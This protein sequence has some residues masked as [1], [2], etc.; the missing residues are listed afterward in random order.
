MIWLCYRAV[1]NFHSSYAFYRALAS[2]SAVVMPLINMSDKCTVGWFDQFA[3][4]IAI[5]PQSDGSTI[6]P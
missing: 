1:V 4:L 2:I 6:W 3:M 5:S